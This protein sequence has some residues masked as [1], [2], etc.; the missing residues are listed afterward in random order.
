MLFTTILFLVF[1]L[2][3][4]LVFW[5][6]PKDKRLIWILITSIIF[7]AA[8][9]I[10]FA[11]HFVGMV[12]LNYF[13]LR[14]MHL[15]RT[16][17]QKTIYMRLAVISNLINLFFF[18]YFYLFLRALHDISGLEIFGK[19]YF[20]NYLSQTTGYDYILLPLAISFYT[21]QLIAYI[22]D[23]YRGNIEKAPDAL[24]FFVFIL[25]FPQLIAGPIMRHSD[26]MTQLLS[27]TPDEKKTQK[28]MY[29]ILLGLI[30]K[31]VIADNAIV[32]IT[33]VFA[34]PSSF[35][36]ISNV[37]AILGFSVQVYC[38]FSGY[39]D[40][41]RG[42][43]FL[44]GL[45]LPRNFIAPYLATSCRDLWTRWH[46]TLSTWLRDYIY[47]P[48][49]GSR[50]GQVMTYL[51]LTITFTL[52]GL[53]HGANYTYIL[54]GFMHGIALAIERLIWS[55]PSTSSLDR[56]KDFLGRHN[57][58]AGGFKYAGIVYTYLIF[59]AGVV[60]FRNQDM[61]HVWEMFGQVFRFTNGTEAASIHNNLVFGLVAIT[62]FFNWLQTK[63]DWIFLIPDRLRYICI[64]VIGVLTMLL[65]GRYSPSGA[66]YI[67]FQF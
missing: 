43:G 10:P 4:Y 31:V 36:T 23:Y 20:N 61:D 62:F 26:F 12:T 56:L 54:W 40:M 34:D 28:G 1:F 6:L 53:W 49:G 66:E 37:A 41:A 55:V 59:L 67:Y 64:A 58:A 13:F 52:G 27:V 30:K 45:K 39:T 17:S 5:S 25:F 60:F 16:R 65:L 29:L 15:A 24:R 8:W 63:P 44:L 21:F 47:I 50:R 57:L 9:S 32:P 19:D 2:L 18:K 11:F 22:V 48:L 35:D 46:I 14:R 33:S 38:D 51:N 42:L 3:V 7:Y